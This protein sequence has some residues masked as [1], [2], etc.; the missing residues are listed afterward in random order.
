MAFI[1]GGETGMSYEDIQRKRQIADSLRANA[2]Q[3][4]RNV[5]EGLAAIGAALAA[6]GIE[7]RAKAADDENRAKSN[8]RWGDVFG[9]LAQAAATPSF[10]PS[11]PVDQNSP[12][13]IAGDTMAA[14]GRG[15]SKPISPDV[16]RQGLIERGMPAHV[17]DGF[18]M[19]FRDESGLNPGINEANPVVPGSRGGFGLAQW[20]GPRRAALEQFAAQSGRDVS[21][22]NVQM[23]FLV[24]E[25]QGPE[26]AAWKAI[27]SAPDAGTAGAEIVNRFLRPAEGHRS[28]RAGQYSG[29]PI[30]TAQAGNFDLATLA[31]LAG[32]PYAS[33]GQKAVVQALM[34]QQMNA[35]D[36][37]R[38]IEL[39][40]A[41][42]ELDGL[43]NPQPKQTDDMREYEF[44][45]SQG[46]Q[47][48]FADY[49]TQIRRAGA[50]SVTIGSEIEARK[51]AAEQLG[52]S[53]DD[54]GY[55]SYIL[56]G[57]MPREDQAPL[58]ATDKK[59]ILEA[60][61]AVQS[62]QT[63]IDMLDGV[64]APGEDGKSLNDKADYGATSG[65]QPWFA[66]N[67]PTGFFDDT[68]GQATTELQNVVLTQA[69][70]QLK[71]TFGAAPTEGERKILVDLQASVDKTPAE[72]AAIIQRAISAAKRR[73]AF[74]Q[75]RAAQLRGG[76]FYKPQGGQP[77]AAPQ[78]PPAAQS[79]AP[80]TH[81]FNP[82]TGK[83]EAIQ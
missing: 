38:A 32:D 3:P 61:E 11:T 15:T 4:A 35:M 28:R 8:E 12:Q 42:A 5:G 13:V 41:Q 6:R 55:Q 79:A 66:R 47:G 63:V 20:T 37:M 76:T 29:Q 67:D 71:A 64:L 74:N 40:R 19:N 82:Q 48:T 46:F 22:P 7:K 52:M 45:K 69:L 31:E 34:Q 18:V 77:E 58:T 36:P 78:Q 1:F 2:I 65:W 50:S 17:A 27:S 57:K 39:E 43:K 33:P 81:R 49:M 70:G 44:A 10:A 21:D 73:L 9:A 72:R 62:N 14:L 56:T 25:L 83:I 60:D 30:R 16:V 80:A 59:A 23:D 24:T 26:A 51:A 68:K 53:P 54:P 75:D